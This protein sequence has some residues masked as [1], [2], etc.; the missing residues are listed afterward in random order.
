MEM[1]VG[2]LAQVIDGSYKG[3]NLPPDVL[4]FRDI[5]KWLHYIHSAKLMHLNIR[6]ENILISKDAR[7]KISD[8]SFVC[9]TTRSNNCWL[10][11]EIL[12][13]MSIGR[14]RG[15]QGDNKN[16]SWKVAPSSDIFSAGC[17]FFFYFTRGVGRGGCAGQVGGFHPFGNGFA[18]QSNN[19]RKNFPVNVEG[20]FVFY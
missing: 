14:T 15:T 17:V 4:V 20:K 5:A 16:V 6:P 3:P 18:E 19:I 9:S 8:F 2:T 1:C 11:P 7:I 12:E 13:M 10:A